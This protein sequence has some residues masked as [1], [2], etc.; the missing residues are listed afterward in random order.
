MT[1][2][3]EA[4]LTS[5]PAYVEPRRELALDMVRLEW[6]HIEVFDSARVLR[7]T[8]RKSIA[9]VKP[10]PTTKSALFDNGASFAMAS[11]RPSPAGL[12][13]M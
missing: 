6:G 2:Q 11:N 3:L 5:R 7:Q 12:P 13:S 9:P 4:W 1:P 8:R 10:L